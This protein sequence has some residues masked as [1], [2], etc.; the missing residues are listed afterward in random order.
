MYMKQAHIGSMEGKRYQLMQ[1]TIFIHNYR[2]F[3]AYLTIDIFYSYLN[4]DNFPSYLTTI[5]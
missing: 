4:I 2:L 1:T 3:P 5:L